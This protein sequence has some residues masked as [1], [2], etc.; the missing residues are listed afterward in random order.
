MET[1]HLVLWYPEQGLAKFSKII[2]IARRI[3]ALALPFT[4]GG[5]SCAIWK[6]QMIV[7][8]SAGEI[9]RYSIFRYPITS[10]E[11]LGWLWRFLFMYVSSV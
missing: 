11:E 3:W 4:V 7:N 6:A 1:Q 9:S 2:H 5:K 10:T 8:H